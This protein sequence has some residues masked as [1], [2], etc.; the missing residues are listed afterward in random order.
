MKVIIT[1]NKLEK[2]AIKWLNDN[3]GDLEPSETEK[4]PDYIFY[5]RGDE[6]IFNYNKKN[7]VVYINYDEIWVFFESFFDMNYQQIQ[8]STKLWVEEH[9]NLRV[10]TTRNKGS[11]ISMG[12]RNITI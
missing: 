6:V 12:W 5:G 4:Y 1:E 8:D 10:S 11:L 2:V 9:Y 7:G 3:Y